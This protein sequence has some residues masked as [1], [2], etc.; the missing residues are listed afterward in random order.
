[1][2]DARGRALRYS[3]AGDGAIRIA[4]RKGESALITAK[5]DRPDLTI[6]PVEPNEAAPKWGL[7][8]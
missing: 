3:D 6:A 5:G 4:L 7:P 1:M 8:A 2:R